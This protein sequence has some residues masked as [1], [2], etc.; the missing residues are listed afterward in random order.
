M[1]RQPI[2]AAHVRWVLEAPAISTLPGR[3]AWAFRGWL[4]AEE[5]WQQAQ[6]HTRAWQRARATEA[7]RHAREYVPRLLGDPALAKARW[8]GYP[9]G[10]AA[11][12]IDG[13]WLRYARGQV[14]LA[15]E[16]PVGGEP[17]LAR[18]AS[19]VE[20]GE[21]V[22]DAATFEPPP[23]PWSCT[24][25]CPTPAPTPAPP[26]P[27]SAG[28]TVFVVGG[29][30]PTESGVLESRFTSDG[31]TR[32]RQVL[33]EL[34]NNHVRVGFTAG[35]LDQARE[36]ADA[37]DAVPTQ[38]PEDGCWQVTLSTGARYWLHVRSATDPDA[39]LDWAGQLGRLKVTGT[40]GAR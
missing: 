31:F 15:V 26:T 10:T 21:L 5:H 34:L 3:A 24:A 32:A 37:A 22:A 33:T 12:V 38:L 2:D 27:A 6:P 40:D 1:T 17:H 13:L 7:A 36:L 39:D 9:D 28:R 4:E 16:C 11:V 18:V 14:F 35:L 30:A 25:L 8:R 19:L 23:P 20:L 29:Q